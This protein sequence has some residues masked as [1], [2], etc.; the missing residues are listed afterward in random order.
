M[1]KIMVY[2]IFQISSKEKLT[3]I[4][5]ELVIK[6]W[7]I[8]CVLMSDSFFNGQDNNSDDGGG[9]SKGWRESSVG[10]ILLRKPIDLNSMPRIHGGTR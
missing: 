1:T 3:L 7:L 8:S 4:M 2:V 5:V 10:K 9:V 6:G